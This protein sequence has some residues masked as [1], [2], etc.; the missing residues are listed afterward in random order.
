[1]DCLQEH[2]LGDRDRYNTLF[3]LARRAR[4]RLCQEQ[5]V[6]NL[7]EYLAP[8][9]QVTA[10]AG[11]QELV[12]FAYELLLELTG[13]E[14]FS[15]SEAVRRL[16]LEVLPHCSDIVGQ[17][18]GRV[19]PSLTN[20]CYNLERERGADWAFWLDKMKGCCQRSAGW[21]QWLEVGQVLAWVSGLAHYR[22][23]A[24]ELAASLPSELV[25][26]L[27]PRWDKVR[28]DPWWPRR[29]ASGKLVR[30]HQLGDFVG[31]GGPFR[32]PPELVSAGSNKF[33]V[34]DGLEE[35][36]LSCDGFGATLKRVKEFPLEE[37]EQNDF[38]VSQDGIIT[39]EGQEFAH[40]ELSPVASFDVSGSVLA[41]TS[42]FSHRVHIF[43][44]TP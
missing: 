2:L 1:M 24:T 33:L 35:W 26:Q 13:V 10:Q 30:A 19:I 27:V 6:F 25:G 37:T 8:L 22:Q 43:I 40:P 18:P 41:V 4:P 32:R 23:S 42:A 31:F 39:F 5:F 16:W 20:A 17:A 11:R 36:L 7:R 34:S 21:E 12:S 15:R 38:Q 44:G 3:A 28:G 9:V 14:L 29:P